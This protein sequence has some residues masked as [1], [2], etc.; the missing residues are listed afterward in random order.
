MTYT[1]ADVKKGLYIVMGILGLVLLMQF[2]QLVLALVLNRVTL[3]TFLWLGLVLWICWATYNGT[4]WARILFSVMM[5]ISGLLL[6]MAAFGGGGGLVGLFGLAQ[7]LCGLCFWVL[8]P[9]NAYFDY[10]AAQNG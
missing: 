6:L 1:A 3:G 8:P 4:L 2:V 9:V 5:L 7:L 10:V